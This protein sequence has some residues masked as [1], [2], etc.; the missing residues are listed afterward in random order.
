MLVRLRAIATVCLVVF[1]GSS[2]ASVTAQPADDQGVLAASMEANY[3]AD[4]VVVS[5]QQAI[6]RALDI[7]PEVSAS[8]AETGKAISLY[9]LAKASRY[10]TQFELTSAFSTAPV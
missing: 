10:L 1:A 6:S 4:T 5:L 8:E 9:N 2:P 7:S 3:S